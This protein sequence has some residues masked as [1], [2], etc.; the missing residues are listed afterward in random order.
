[1]ILEYEG[2]DSV[3]S[4]MKRDFCMHCVLYERII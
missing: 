4:P 3:Q 1:M 2:A